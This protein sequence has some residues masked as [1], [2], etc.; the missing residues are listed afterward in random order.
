MK[1]TFDKDADAAYIYL[2]NSP[3]KSSKTVCGEGELEGFNF[4]F[5]EG[6]RLLGIEVLGASKSLDKQILK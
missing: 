6:G 1:I 5:D 4:D 3:V 2:T